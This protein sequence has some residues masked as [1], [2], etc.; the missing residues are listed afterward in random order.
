MQTTGVD[1]PE[2]LAQP[3]PRE[4]AETAISIRNVTQ[5]YGEVGASDAVLALDNISLDIR[6]GEFV[7]L[8]GPSGCGKSTLLNIVGGLF[9]PTEG[10]VT[11]GGRRV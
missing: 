10:E 6:R 11:V 8:L 4:A 9:R 5:R 1:T 7:C 3:T 2:A